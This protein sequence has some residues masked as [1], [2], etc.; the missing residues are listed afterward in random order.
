MTSG[1]ERLRF[2]PDPCIS[3]FGKLTSMS[4]S[5]SG[6]ST[7]GLEKPNVGNFILG[8]L[9][10]PDV[11]RSASRSAPL[12]SAF[13][14][15]RS[16]SGEDRPP[17]MFG[18][19]RF[20]FGALKSALGRFAST[21]GIERSTF[22][23][24]S[25]SSSGPFTFGVDEL[26]LGIFKDGNLYTWDEAPALM[27]AFGT[28]MSRLGASM[29]PFISGIDRSGDLSSRF[30]D[31]R[32]KLGE[33]AL[34]SMSGPFNLGVL[35]F[36]IWNLGSLSLEEGLSMSTPGALRSTAGPLRSALGKVIPISGVSTS[37]PS[38]GAARF[39]SAP[40]TSISG[41]SRSK[42]DDLNHFGFL[43]VGH[44]T[45]PEGASISI[46]GADKSILGPSSD[47]ETFGVVRSRAGEFT[48]ALRSTSGAFSLGP[49][50]QFLGFL[51]VRN[52]FFPDEAGRSTSGPVRSPSRL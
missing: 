48:S 13:G 6:P 45:F 51:R 47:P 41:L 2:A 42:L 30:C 52:F 37:P 9:N 10:F 33:S 44:L 15:L 29:P 34:A 11:S 36:G 28:S 22:V 21:P 5:R 43:R 27:S 35:N 17:S 4:A 26:Q 40:F 8:N 12:I 19:E 24:S 49:I 23:S 25:P 46:F 32:S 1:A 31:F 50:S 16:R 38:V 39:T 3:A 14:K 18:V 7:L 20:K